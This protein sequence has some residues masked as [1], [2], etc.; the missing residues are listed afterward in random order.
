M[1]RL[2]ALCALLLVGLSGPAP[3]R[4]Y[5]VDDLLGLESL[6][7]VQIDPTAHWVVLERR[8]PWKDAASFIY[9]GLTPALL[10]QLMVADL[11]HPGPVRP[12][13]AQDPTA[14]YQAGPISPDG[15]QMLVY[16]LQG[17]AF[18]AGIAVLATGS[19]RW[20]GIAP[21]APV[22]GRAA[23]WRSAH[24]LVLIALPRGGLPR[25]LGSRRGVQDRLPDLWRQAAAGREVSVSR[26]GSGRFLG[27]KPKAAA[28]QLLV[29]DTTTGTVS[30]FAEGQFNDLELSPDGR[31]AALVED[32]EDVQPAAEDQVHVSSPTRRRGLL[33]IDLRSGALIRPALGHDLAHGL[34]AW[35][36]KG[37]DLLIQLRRPDLAAEGRSL[38][39]VSAAT[40]AAQAVPTPRLVLALSRNLE[41]STYARAD[42]M[43]EDP[44]AFAQR[45]DG[46]QDWYRLASAGPVRLTGGLKAPPR[47]ILGLGAQHLILAADGQVWRVGANGKTRAVAAS[48]VPAQVGGTRLRENPVLSHEV[49][50]PRPGTSPRIPAGAEVL[51]ASDHEAVVASKTDH[52]V[53]SVAVVTAA[54]SRPV[55]TLNAGLEDVTAADILPVRHSGR[56][57]EPLTSWLYLPH[58]RAPGARLPLVVIPYRGSTYGRPAAIYA[59][60]AINTYSNA[61]ILV[62]A[63]YAV[64]TP[65]LPY[66]AAMDGPTLGVAADILRAVDAALALGG[67][68]PG[69]IALFGHSFGAINAV[70]A[71]SQSS[72]FKSVI[73]ASGIHDEISSW[74]EFLQ[75]N[76]I[77]PEQGLSS[78][79]TAGLVEQGQGALAAPPWK[80]PQRYLKAS[81]VFAADRITAPVLI[82]HGDLDEI[83]ATQSQELFTALYRQAKDAE[84]VT[85]WGEG[86]TLASPANIRDQ[87]ATIL[88]WLALTMPPASGAAR[89]PPPSSSAPDRSRRA[90]SGVRG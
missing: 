73:A 5:G 11:R 76:W 44:V 89:P 4:P 69:R 58:D 55:L 82:I 26:I 65:S 22:Y 78:P 46:R 41:G 29:V 32:R 90:R 56:H 14:G 30:P 86:H 53:L 25:Q 51:A 67:L 61:Q 85:Y 16:R 59:P 8:R 48:P 1:R 66:D 15:A 3:A 7:Q 54:G 81:N 62:G 88:D 31:F 45:P 74:G 13:F 21:D 10:S 42:W 57:G 87:F 52:G 84:L 75:Y 20:T 38:A 68:D 71:A 35:S 12:L 36:P 27:E 2:P 79:L 33:L 47:Q 37:D 39:R 40:G 18:E 64:L 72:R 60:D 49:P 77:A 23:Q 83:R 43:G 19:V 80:A 28:K 6:G 9:G 34:L 24:E 63:G 17:A 50:A 70:A